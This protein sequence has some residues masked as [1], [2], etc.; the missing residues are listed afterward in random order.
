MSLVH[1]LLF[2]KLDELLFREIPCDNF[3]KEYWDSVFQHCISPFIKGIRDVNRIINVYRFK[4]GLMHNETNCIDLLALTTFQIC[5][6]SI[7]NWIYHNEERVIGSSYGIGM[8]GIEQNKTK[9]ILLEEFK[10]VYETSPELMLQAI[11]TLFPKF[12]W[13]SGGYS[14]QCE[15]DE[16]LRKK[17][18]IA[19]STRFPLYFNLSLE[20]IAITKQQIIESIN[21]YDYTDLKSFFAKLTFEDQLYEYMQELISYVSDMPTQRLSIFLKVLVEAQTVEKNYE[22]K[23]IFAPIPAYKCMKC[24]W[25]IFQ[26]LGHDQTEKEIISILESSSLDEFSVIV[27]MIVSI[28]RSY[29]RIGDSLGHDYR[30]VEEKQLDN[31]EESIKNKLELLSKEHNLLDAYAFWNIYHIWNYIDRESMNNYLKESLKT[32]SNVPKYLS[33]V[34]ISWN[35]SNDSGWS[36]KEENFSDG[37]TLETAYE[38]IVNLKCTIE[39]SELKFEVKEMAIAFYL[40]YN[41]DRKDKT[42]V[43]KQTV[44]ELIPQWEKQSN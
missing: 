38:Q 4:Y 15:T 20:N 12:S 31:I 39:F 37:I 9:N 40:W 21:N 28:E 41:T 13:S 7:F 1:Q 18:K 32:A 14:H 42:K 19:C 6:P 26:R 43:S 35:G 16:E 44:D 8:T 10:G 27:G 34:A 3:E 30:V 29:S 5:A 17:Q 22:H 23:G 33:I 2:D 36:F 11:Q 25:A 24:C